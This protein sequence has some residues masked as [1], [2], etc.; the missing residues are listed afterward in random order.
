MREKPRGLNSCPE[1]K[2]C[3]ARLVNKGMLRR[4]RGRKE[5]KGQEGPRS[6]SEAI[7]QRSVQRSGGRSRAKF[8]WGLPK[9]GPVKGGGGELHAP[10]AKVIKVGKPS[11]NPVNQSD[12]RPLESIGRGKRLQAPIR[13]FEGGIFLEGSEIRS[14][15]ERKRSQGSAAAVIL[16][17]LKMDSTGR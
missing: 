4:Q 10:Q 8:Q 1:K 17:A 15:S 6:K 9:Y 7:F 11:D 16:P 5:T 13:H 3:H 14:L 12:T 2:E